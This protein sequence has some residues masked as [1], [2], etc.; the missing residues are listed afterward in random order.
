[1]RE[2]ACEPLKGR[3]SVPSSSILLLDTIPH[4]FMFGGLIFPMQDPKVEV[5]DVGPK[6]LAP[7]GE[8]LYF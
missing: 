8:V 2:S 7:Q 5:S 4:G 3:F 1:M 6:P